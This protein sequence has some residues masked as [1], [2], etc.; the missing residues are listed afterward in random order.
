MRGSPVTGI[1]ALVAALHV[2]VLSLVFGPRHVGYMLS[3]ALSAI[4]IWC[5]VY[6][7]S[8]RRRPASLIAG[9]VIGLALQQ[10]AY[11]VWKTQL[12]GFW[13]PL[14]QFGAL[15]FLVVYVASHI[16]VRQLPGKA[17]D[18]TSEKQAQSAAGA[19]NKE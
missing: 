11:R 9:V 6:V 15:Q 10:V 18:V 16:A 19:D 8:E 14:A 3:A 1:V 4:L 13:W 7:L 5:V 17:I 12:P 2:A